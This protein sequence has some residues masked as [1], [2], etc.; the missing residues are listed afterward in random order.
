MSHE[1]KQTHQLEGVILIK[2]PNWQHYHTWKEITYQILG[3]KV[4]NITF[5]LVMEIFKYVQESYWR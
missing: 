3:V 2:T 4:L 5:S 1:K